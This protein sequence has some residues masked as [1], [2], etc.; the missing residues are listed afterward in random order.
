MVLLERVV[1][2]MGSGFL[3]WAMNFSRVGRVFFPSVARLLVLGGGSEEE[4]SIAFLKPLVLRN[5]EHNH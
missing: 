3:L 5:E 2:G 1:P 4:A